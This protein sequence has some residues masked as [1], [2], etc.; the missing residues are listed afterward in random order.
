[1]DDIL[2]R[3][4][5]VE[6]EAEALVR[7]AE[8]EAES[9]LAAARRDA[10]AVDERAQHEINAETQALIDRE[11]TAAEQRKAEALAAAVETLAAR[12]TELR[13]CLATQT[14]QVVEAVAY[15]LRRDLG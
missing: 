12:A 1:M 6:Q 5:Q 15:P 3:M 13:A 8:I 10:S 7:E 14:Q 2:Q 11:I 9:I 4:L